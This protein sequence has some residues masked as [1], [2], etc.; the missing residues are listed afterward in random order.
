VNL[1]ALV[2]QALRMIQPQTEEKQLVIAT[3]GLRALPEIRADAMRMQ[4][5]FLNLLSN[6]VKFTSEGGR[7]TV[8]G[9]LEADG[10]VRIAV[11]DTGIGIA[12]SDI[13]KI[14]MPFELVESAFAR[15][16]KGTGLGLPLAKSLVEMHGGSLTV[17]SAP[18]RGTTVVIALPASRIVRPSI[19]Q[20]G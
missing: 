10:A 13:P 4:Q 6:A 5:V 17:E 1:D 12:L 16:Y 14:L 19:A 9:A 11:S 18:G 3:E 15:K 20:A 8:T 7:I 2:S